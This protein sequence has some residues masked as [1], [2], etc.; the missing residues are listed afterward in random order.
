MP[1]I[2]HIL[3]MIFEPIFNLTEQ[4][5]SLPPLFELAYIIVN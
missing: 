4:Y 1:V 3:G 2:H 5:V